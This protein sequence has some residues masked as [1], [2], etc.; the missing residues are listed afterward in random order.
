VKISVLACIFLSTSVIAASPPSTPEVLGVALGASVERLQ[1]VIPQFKCYGATCVFDP[2]DAA[3][4]RCGEASSSPGVLDCY[5]QSGA[6][7]AFVSTHGAKYTAY[8]KDGR[9][10]EFRVTFPTSSADE[11][12]KALKEN[13]GPPA[14]DREFDTENRLGLKF[15][16]RAVIWRLGDS[17]ITVERR[18]V[19]VDTG[20]A[21]IVA[22]W[23]RH[24]TAGDQEIGGKSDAGQ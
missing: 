11:V 20:L 9:V 4:A 3:Y 17:E 18:S 15:R 16:N 2:I 24:A 13:Y 5:A 12:V 22:T 10:G 1:Q 8:L 19:D 23:Y 21:T 14:D 7:Y 6:D